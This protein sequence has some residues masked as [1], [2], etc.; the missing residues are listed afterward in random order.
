MYWHFLYSQ[1]AT[2]LK[3]YI[4][5]D[6]RTSD[7]MWGN[8]QRLFVHTSLWTKIFVHKRI[9]WVTNSQCYKIQLVFSN[10]LDWTSKSYRSSWLI[11]YL[12]TSWFRVILNCLQNCNSYNLYV[13]W[14]LPTSVTTH[15]TNFLLYRFFHIHKL[16]GHEYIRFKCIF[17]YWQFKIGLKV[18]SL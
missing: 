17:T 2:S 1:I 10:S 8:Q 3:S 7:G 12:R 6:R 11:E 13:L 14:K 4:V 5:T 15:C 16:N 18:S 9:N